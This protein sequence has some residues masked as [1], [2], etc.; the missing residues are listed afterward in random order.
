MGAFNGTIINA[1]TYQETGSG[2]YTDSTVTLTSPANEFRITPGKLDKSGQRICTWTFIREFDVT[3]G[4]ILTRER[5]VA[6]M[7]LRAG[8]NIAVV[9]L[10]QLID[11]TAVV[12]DSDRLIRILLGA[13]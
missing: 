9:D 10:Q 4:G 12:P 5:A 8:V 6:S 3:A 13:S 2:R 1:K 11:D 7:N